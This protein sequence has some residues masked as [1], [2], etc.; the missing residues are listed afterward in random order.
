MIYMRFNSNLKKRLNNLKMKK[1]K[2]KFW[3][4]INNKIEKDKYDKF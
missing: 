4:L 2:K 1:N 3:K